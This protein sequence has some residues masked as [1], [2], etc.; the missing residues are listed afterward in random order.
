MSIE[1][2][3]LGLTDVA[4]GAG[5]QLADRAPD[6]S[7]RLAEAAPLDRGLVGRGGPAAIGA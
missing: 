2:R 3:R 5:P 6:R 7:D 4:G 1:D